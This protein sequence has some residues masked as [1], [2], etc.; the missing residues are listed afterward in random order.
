MASKKMT[1]KEPNFSITD[2]PLTL[3]QELL[4]LYGGASLNLQEDRLYGDFRLIS[5]NDDSFLTE[6]SI[7]T[8]LR[9]RRGYLTNTYFKV[10]STNDRADIFDFTGYAIKS[11]Q[12]SLPCVSWVEVTD[13]IMHIHFD[14]V[15][16]EQLIYDVAAFAYAIGLGDRELKVTIDKIKN[17]E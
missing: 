3:R 5:R 1:S 15:D 6:D 2:L 12:P 17:F 11:N 14:R 13:E 9:D 7:Y 4:R 16:E 8:R 10:L